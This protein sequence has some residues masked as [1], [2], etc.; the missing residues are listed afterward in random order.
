M[1]PP[2]PPPKKTTTTTSQSRDYSSFQMPFN[3]TSVRVEGRPGGGGGGGRQKRG[4]AGATEAAFPLRLPFSGS[5]RTGNEKYRVEVISLNA[6][7]E[8][9]RSHYNLELSL[10]W[11]DKWR[12]HLARL[13]QP[14]ARGQTVD[15]L[16]RKFAELQ[17]KL[18]RK[19]PFLA[20]VPKV[21]LVQ[22]DAS[23]APG[24]K[25]HFEVLLP[26]HTRMTT[27]DPYLWEAMGFPTELVESLSPDV[28]G[29]T[30]DMSRHGFSNS[31]QDLL[32]FVG[33][34]L[35]AGLDLD[36]SYK[37]V[38]E[39]S[40]PLRQ[41]LIQV[42]FTSK[43][44]F[45][46]LSSKESKPMDVVGATTALAQLVEAGLGKLNLRSSFLEVQAPTAGEL[47]FRSREFGSGDGGEEASC[48][49]DVR[50]SPALAHFLSLTDRL[51]TFPSDDKREFTVTLPPESSRR[52]D[53]LLRRYP[54]SLMCT[55]HGSG[56]HYIEGMGRVS[57][58]AYA[59][60]PDHFRGDGI[61]VQG[62]A[63]ELRLFFVDLHHEVV[64]NVEDT[65][66][67]LGLNITN[68]F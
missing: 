30:G 61:V 18:K 6:R 48:E 23:S 50:F 64:P 28:E 34:D 5:N 63:D 54:L 31:S 49:L 60:S 62:E 7:V 2:P 58:L 29:E 66:Y 56:D 19:Y 12:M 43:G 53:P 38:S 26:A 36:L 9:S 22:P 25:L 41:P 46:P 1:P 17:V 14:V 45:L 33:A 11:Q 32:V 65:S 16:G 57:L 47:Q 52:P 8:T 4:T 21:E 68:L 13:D 15:K 20:R 55:N 39:D 24:T 37:T 44:E 59:L 40:T 27:D 51:V 35:P 42:D 67:F 10:V 3:L